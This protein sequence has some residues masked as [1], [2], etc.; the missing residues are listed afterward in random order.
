MLDQVGRYT[1]AAQNR[2]RLI[3]KASPPQ[4]LREFGLFVLLIRACC[5]YLFLGTG[6]VL[7]R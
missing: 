6:G 7:D 1:D 5:S 2:K 3:G 4:E